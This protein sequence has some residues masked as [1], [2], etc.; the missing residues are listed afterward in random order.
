MSSTSILLGAGFSVPAGYP[1]GVELNK[2]ILEC[3][4]TE[5][6]FSR[7]GR[8]C[9]DTSVAQ[10]ESKYK[11]NSTEDVEFDFL[12]ALIKYY[13]KNIAAFDYEEFYDFLVDQANQDRGVAEFAEPFRKLIHR[14]TADLIYAIRKMY[15]Q[16]VTH[17]LVDIEGKKWYDNE[18][19]HLKPSFQGYT[20]FLNCLEH[21]GKSGIVN[22]HTLNHDLFF[23]RLAKTEWIQ[24]ELSDGFQ[25]LGTPY[26]GEVSTD[27]GRSKIRLPYY[28]GDYTNKFRLYKLH[29]SRDYLVFYN[30]SGV[31]FLPD[32]YIKIRNGI[33][34]HDLYKEMEKENGE[35]SYESC[36]VN[37]HA[38]FFI[39][40]TKK[41]ERYEEPLL[42]NKL[43]EHFRNNLNEAEQLIII[44][45]GAKDREIN[46]I[47]IDHFDFAA[48][49]CFIVNP[50]PDKEV[51]ELKE[52]LGAVLIKDSL[53]SLTLDH[54][55]KISND[56]LQRN[57]GN[58]KK[59]L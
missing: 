18:P 12:L 37:Y 19:Y 13:E 35:L 57:S 56:D 42:F 22:I 5:F 39:G 4:G 2:R 41:I 7:H 44:G 23:E 8:L 54:F 55:K 9:V 50:Y 47:L 46:R 45:Y 34:L 11:Y 36:W 48:K 26:Y 14:K 52:S 1:T 10:K 43:F 51:L 27:G 21:W 29:G 58:L 28:L 30:S 20:G 15:F 49:P 17:Y 40:I 31:V 3:K 33:A 32:S 25:E 53:D 24:R 16:I 38:D 59:V 6:G